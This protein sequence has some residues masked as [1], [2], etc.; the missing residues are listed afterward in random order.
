MSDSHN[1]KQIRLN[2]LEGRKLQQAMRKG[3]TDLLNQLRNPLK[4]GVET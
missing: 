3:R 1:T 2:R 4:M